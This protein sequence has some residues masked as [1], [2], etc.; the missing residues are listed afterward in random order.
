[1]VQLDL[2]L[3]YASVAW[4]KEGR[5]RGFSDSAPTCF[6]Y[7]DDANVPFQSSRLTH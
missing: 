3:A 1:M 2:D 6:E 4:D 5:E 7:S